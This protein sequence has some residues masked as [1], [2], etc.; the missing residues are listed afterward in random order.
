MTDFNKR[1]ISDSP[2]IYRKFNK[3]EQLD[4]LH[5]LLT[6]ISNQVN[7]YNFTNEYLISSRGKLE[8][9]IYWLNLIILIFLILI[10]IN[11]FFS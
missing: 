11:L 3:D 4:V 2:I 6:N 5:L 8:K 10:F 1:K 9:Q 7:S